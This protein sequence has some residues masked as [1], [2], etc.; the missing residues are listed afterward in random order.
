MY[1]DTV[2]THQQI[3]STYFMAMVWQIFRYQIFSILRCS[4]S[5]SLLYVNDPLCQHWPSCPT[6]SSSSPRWMLP[7]SAPW[8]AQQR[9][10]V[11]SC[12]VINSCPAHDDELLPLHYRDGPNRWEICGFRIKAAYE[13]HLCGKA[14]KNVEFD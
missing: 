6:F 11:T 9:G 4:V 7:L 14:K 12:S 5:R 8:C 10:G 2:R 13:L 3:F 1:S